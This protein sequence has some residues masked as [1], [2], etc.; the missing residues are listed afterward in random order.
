MFRTAA[1]S[2]PS[3]LRTQRCKSPGGEHRPRMW[4]TLAK[5]C[6]QSFRRLHG[7]AGDTAAPYSVSALGYSY[8]HSP[9]AVAAVAAAPGWAAG[10]AGVCRIGG[11]S[12]LQNLAPSS[13]SSG[14]FLGAARSS[15]SSTT[16]GYAAATAGGRMFGN[17]VV[18]RL[19]V[20]VPEMPDWER[21]YQ[22]SECVVV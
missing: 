17:M 19:P 20:V 10:A 14:I 18:E 22:V 12:T 15:S 13:S 9:A 21:E 11:S 5:A 3:S 16:R 2:F 6:R 7:V 1:T 4:N 8:H